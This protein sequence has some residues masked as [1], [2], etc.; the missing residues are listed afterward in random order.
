MY[1]SISI[2]SFTFWLLPQFQYYPI[3]LLC[4]FCL[5][6]EGLSR[7]LLILFLPHSVSAPQI[8]PLFSSLVSHSPDYPAWNSFLH[9]Q[10]WLSKVISLPSEASPGF[11]H[12]FSA[13]NIPIQ[14]EPNPSYIQSLHNS[15]HTP[16]SQK[17]MKVFLWIPSMK[18]LN[19]SKT[20]D[21]QYQ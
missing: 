21:L 20:Q 16:E 5:L 1:K 4:C 3:L 10:P 8:K 9:L 17:D 15:M 18:Y 2:N 13:V 11:W 7:H 6:L 14:R 12:C 19:F